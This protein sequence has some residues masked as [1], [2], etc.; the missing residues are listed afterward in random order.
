[1]TAEPLFAP[2]T[3][4]PSLAEPATGLSPRADTGH[5]SSLAATRLSELS[6]L[7]IRLPALVGLALAAV[8]DLAVR[9]IKFGASWSAQRGAEWLR[10]WSRHAL[11]VM[12]VR[13]TVWGTPPTTGLLAANHPGP[14]GALLLAVVQPLVFVARPE[15]WRWSWCRA[16]ARVAGTL[17]VH[18]RERGQVMC[19]SAEY[20]ARVERGNVMAVF[21]AGC[22][23]GG[24]TIQPFHSSLLV[25]ATERQWPATPVWI[26]CAFADES[27]A[28]DGGRRRGRSFMPPL[29]DWLK[30]R[31]IR[32]VVIYGDPVCG[33]RE[34]KALAREL[35]RRV[36]ALASDGQSLLR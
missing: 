10:L 19:L 26:G 32:A 27:R 5:R 28:R 7:A 23:D 18:H 14:L 9:R 2:M 21:P 36:R 20:A 6:R 25:P 17:F 15:Q 13:V 33:H 1:M 31:E 4:V 3:V 11:R 34:R 29:L 30:Q 16:L 24:E 35:H 22:T 8:T 12:Q